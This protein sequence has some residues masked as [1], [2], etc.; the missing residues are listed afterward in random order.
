M[1]MPEATTQRPCVLFVHW[2]MMATLRPSGKPPAWFRDAAAIDLDEPSISE[3][4]VEKVETAPPIKYERTGQIMFALAVLAIAAPASLLMRCE[5]SECEPEIVFTLAV[6]AAAMIGTLPALLLSVFSAL[7]FNY[8]VVPP[9]S[10]FTIPTREEIVYF[11]INI[12][13]SIGI[14]L[15]LSWVIEGRKERVRT[16][17]T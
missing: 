17:N 13:V 2:P 12:L 4:F 6:C 15:F 7:V 14:P 10:A 1:R 8:S 16:P 11:L 9:E 3:S 5:L